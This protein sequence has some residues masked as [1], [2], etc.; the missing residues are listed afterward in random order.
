MNAR[1]S[2]LLN[3]TAS[4]VLLMTTVAVLGF[5]LGAGAGLALEGVTLEGP[6]ALALPAAYDNHTEVGR[7]WKE[8]ERERDEL[9][10]NIL[11][12]GHR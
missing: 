3:A 5:E 4:S 9:G 1:F 2:F 8:R 10:H 6:L 11:L 7:R 12:R